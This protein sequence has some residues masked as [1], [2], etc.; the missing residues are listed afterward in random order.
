MNGIDIGTL[1]IA[2]KPISNHKG[3]NIMSKIPTGITK[4]HIGMVRKSAG[5]KRN[6][7]PH[8][9]VPVIEAEI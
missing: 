6:R 3:I 2:K 7:Y 9:T 8:S 1:N 4:P 5:N